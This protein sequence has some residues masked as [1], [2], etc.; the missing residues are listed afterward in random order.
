MSLFSRLANAIR[1]R[2]LDQ[3]L[4]EEQRFHLESRTAEYAREGLAP[5]DAAREARRRFGNPLRLRESSRDA[6]IVRWLDSLLRDIR[7]GVRMLGKNRAVT[8][9]AF[10]SLSLAI[11][12]CTS[13]FSLVDAL[14]LRPLPVRDPASLFTVTFLRDGREGVSFNYP[15]YQRFRAAAG[16]KAELFTA[17][18]PWP[19]PVTIDG[20]GQKETLQPQW[21]SGNFFGVLGIDP[22]LGRVLTPDDDRNPGQHPVAV[23]SYSFWQRRFGGSPEILGRWFELEDKR[24]QVIGVARQGFFGIEPGVRIDLWVPNMMWS[25]RALADSSYSWFRILG[26][27][28]AGVS[29]PQVREFLQ[30]SFSEF[31]RERAADMP[32][33]TPHAQMEMLLRTPLIV[34]PAANGPSQFRTEFTR[35]LIILAVVAGLIL[36]IAC[37]NLANLFLARAAAREREMAMRISIGAGRARL[38]QQVLVES[39]LLALAST[40]AGVVLAAATAPAVIAAL[41]TRGNPLWLDLHANWRVV[42]CAAGIGCSTMLL[43]GLLPALRAARVSPDRV[44][45]A[46]SGRHSGRIALLRPLIAVQVGF[47]FAVLFVGG[48]LLTTFRNLATADLGFS[49]TGIVLFQIDRHRLLQ[50]DAERAAALDLL[51][52]TRRLPGVIGAGTSGYALFSGSSRDNNIRVPG[53]PLESTTPYLLEVS[54]GFFQAM[55]IRLLAGRDLSPRDTDPNVPSVV[56]NQAFADHFLPGADPLGKVFFRVI[57]RDNLIRCEIVG[58]VRNA[59]YLNIREPE[60]PT[61]YLPI[62]GVYGAT[63]AVRTAGDAAADIPSLRRE[64]ERIN[65]AVRLGD[66]NLQSALIANVMLHERLLALLA[67]FFAA[68]ALA[69]AAIGLYG[70]LS[71]TIVRRTREIGIRVALGARPRGVVRMVVADVAVM[72]AIG[73]A[74]GAVGGVVFGG[75]LEKLLYKVKP[76]EAWS[77]AVPLAVLLIAAAASAIPPALRAARVDP[78]EA[79]RCE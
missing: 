8:A 39:G 48:L 61:A 65:P 15:L 22:A 31:R 4:A 38:I 70:V 68:V 60:R 14:I 56:V 9:A 67:A 33:D 6:R 27:T 20:A 71:Y 66:A 78:M 5:D 47:S 64:I 79:L 46:E 49:K 62:H 59:K 73:L 44:L 3:E 28:R 34:S 35:P 19:R 40:V 24:Y 75:S 41:S 57:G 29:K 51:D 26:R 2:R 16:D 23:L 17:T 1:S 37:S 32:P 76:S 63:L 21:V 42:A 58:V 10:L 18:T 77:Y 74:V 43:F 12:A 7:F 52:Q 53:R 55:G 11:G 45:R 30:P 69:L 54:P 13:A 36:L 50:P 25:A 72:M